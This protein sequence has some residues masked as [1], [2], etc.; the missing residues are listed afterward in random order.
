MV[1]NVKVYSQEKK[2]ECQTLLINRPLYGVA[3]HIVIKKKQAG[4]FFLGQIQAGG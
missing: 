1:K 4:G 2:K 3:F